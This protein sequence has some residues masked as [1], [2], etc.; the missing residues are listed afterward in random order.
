MLECLVS[1]GDK[2]WKTIFKEYVLFDF[3]YT[4]NSNLDYNK[5][6]NIGLI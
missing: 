2:L 3:S 1:N 6:L 4:R 5:T